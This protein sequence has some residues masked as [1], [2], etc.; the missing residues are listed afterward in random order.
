MCCFGGKVLSVP[1]EVPG[2]DGVDDDGSGLNRRPKS[3]MSRVRS[4]VVEVLRK[5]LGVRPPH[6][7]RTRRV[8]VGT[9]VTRKAPVTNTK[10]RRDD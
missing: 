6:T 8:G 3:R 5:G 4:T 2:P 9:V 7:G 10:D 1:S